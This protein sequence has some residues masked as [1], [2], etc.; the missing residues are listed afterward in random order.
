MTLS[1]KTFLRHA[2]LGP[3]GLAAATRGGAAQPAAPDGDGALPPYSEAGAAAF[4]AAVRDAYPLVRELTYFNTGGLGPSCR[5]ALAAADRTTRK[6]QER[7]EH[8]HGLFAGARATAARF[9]GGEAAE[10]AFVRNATEGNAIVAAGLALRAGDEVILDSHA[11]PGGSFAWLQQRAARGVVVRVFE[12]DAQDAAGNVE[13]I[14]KLMTPRTR[15]VQISHVTAPTGILLPAERIAALCRERGAWFHV[16]AAQSVGMLQ[17]DV[18]RLGC[19]S[20]ATSG[21]K[22]LGAPLETGLLWVKR[23]RIAEVASPLVGAYSGDLPDGGSGRAGGLAA[24]A[25]GAGLKLADTAERFEYGTRNPAAA[26]G[27]AAAIAF[28]EQIGRARLER[29]VREL[30]TGLHVRLAAIRGVEV[31]TP[32]DAGLR[33]AMVTF[34]CARVTHDQLFG[35]LLKD[36]AMRCRPV[37]EEGLNALRVSTHGFNSVAE[38]DA[39]AAAV[40]KIAG[41]AA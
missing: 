38:C 34:R 35:R 41:G 20:L 21:H 22:W 5:A 36:H 27:L 25:A 9:L 6:L 32:A 12:P 30:A 2:A 29:R 18:R 26:V 8:G 16:D 19:D 1:R 13:R 4:W 28:Q 17:V 15:V 11:H 23:E 3:L 7:A 24:A 37:T 31:L 33:T 14:R 39:L 10:L 40:E